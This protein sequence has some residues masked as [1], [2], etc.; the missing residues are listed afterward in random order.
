MEDSGWKTA[1]R[2]LSVRCST[3]YAQSST[4]LSLPPS[5]PSLTA[6]GTHAN[7]NCPM[8]DATAPSDE[9]AAPAPDAPPPASAPP[10]DEGQRLHPMTL[11]QRVLVSLPALGFILL[12]LVTNPN[13]DSYFS[14]LFAV[15]YGVVALPLIALQ[16]LRFRYWVTPSQIII[17][18][19]VFRRQHRSIPIERVQNVQIVQSL[20][21]RLLRTAKV[22]VETAGSG[23]TEG[24]LEYVALDEAHRIREAVR[25]FQRQKKAPR[26]QSG[27][28]AAKVPANPEALEEEKEA[29]G[30]TLFEMSV[31]RVLLAGAFQFSLL[32]IALAFSFLQYV[33]LTPDEALQWAQRGPLHD[34]AEAALAQPWLAVALTLVA[35]ALLAWLSGLLLTFNHD[36]SFRLRLEEGKLHR[37]HGL[38]TRSEGTIPLDK[39]QALVLRTN[40]LKRLFGWYGLEVQTMGLE[41]EGHQVAVP[42]AQRTEVERIAQHIHPAVWPEQFR[43]V[44]PLTIRRASVRYA[45]LLA[46]VVMPVATFLYAPAWWAL[47]LAPLLVG[48]AYLQ[49]RCHGYAVREDALY[50]RRG[51]FQQHCWMLPTEKQQVFYASASLFQRRLHLKSLYVDTAGAGGFSTPEVVDLPAPEADGMLTRLYARFYTHF[52]DGASES[53][54]SES[55]TSESGTSESGAS[56]ELDPQQTAAPADSD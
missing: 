4:P 27:L 48:L 10:P 30:E 6:Q 42:F 17:Q 44:S 40:P 22:K 21:P 52:E 26:Q 46:V 20:L 41:A 1:D 51:V 32:Y 33:D 16:Y 25:S 50:V 5:S 43:R 18:R 28:P 54:T 15:L 29:P 8:T 19:G 36:Y 35:T 9:P 56:Q 45:V 23:S 11:L 13:A 37:R 39:V 24:T 38:L 47:A 31:G 12:P 2:I 53:G 14:L 7:E 34:W 3:L 49:Y 55:G